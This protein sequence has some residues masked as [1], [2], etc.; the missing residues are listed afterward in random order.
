MGVYF[1]AVEHSLT[2]VRGVLLSQ[3]VLRR[4]LDGVWNRQSVGQADARCERDCRGAVS[5]T[6][7][8]IWWAWGYPSCNGKGRG[9][10]ARESN[11]YEN[12][13][14]FTETK[15]DSE[16]SLIYCSF[17]GHD[18]IMNVSYNSSLEGTPYVAT[19]NRY[20]INS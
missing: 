20:P 19:R 9:R 16:D 17:T 4:C 8:W 2:S 6:R 7:S 14:I 1:M 5:Y 3:D 12:E 10:S 15:S 18:K 11:E 13:V